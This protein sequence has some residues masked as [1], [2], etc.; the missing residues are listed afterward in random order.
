M[1]LSFS[2]MTRLY[3]IKFMNAYYTEREREREREKARKNRIELDRVG[4][5]SSEEL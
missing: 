5:S 4:W 3:R 2:E 1:D